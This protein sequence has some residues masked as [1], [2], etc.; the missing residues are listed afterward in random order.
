MGRL[1]KILKS[2]AL[3]QFRVGAHANGLANA[4]EL[5]K[6]RF[7]MDVVKNIWIGSGLV[8]ICIPYLYAVFPMML[9]ATFLSFMI[10]DE[11]G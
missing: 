9:L 4:K 6:H 7:K 3:S 11:T 10:L 8:M 2:C 1:I 5:K